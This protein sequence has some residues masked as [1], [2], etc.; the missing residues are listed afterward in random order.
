LL[1]LRS[2]AVTPHLAAGTRDAL[3]TKMRA[4]FANVS[5]FYTGG[6]LANRVADP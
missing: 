6:E 5:R 2:G 4:L 1:A 3:R